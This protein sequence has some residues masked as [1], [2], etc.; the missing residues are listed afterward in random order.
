MTCG[1][2]GVCRP[3]FRKVP[4][5]NYRNLRSYP[6]LW[7]ILEENHPFFAIFRQLLDNPPL[8]M[9]NLP[10]KGPLFRE[11]GAQKPTHMGGTYPYPQHV[12]YPP[13]PGQIW[14]GLNGAVTSYELKIGWTF[15][16]K[17]AHLEDEKFE[18]CKLRNACKDVYKWHQIFLLVS[19]KIPW[20]A[21]SRESLVILGT[22]KTDSAVINEDS[23]RDQMSFL[24][25]LANSSV[26]L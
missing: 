11:F 10:K 20:V 6:L 7:W 3:V 5:S 22:C 16:Y 19:C 9:E 2:T 26:V 24:W 18:S 12:M 23:Y 21:D 14:T 25:S 17:M 13:P 8:F 1:W 4:S 15:K